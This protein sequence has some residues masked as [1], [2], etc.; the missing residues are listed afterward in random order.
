MHINEHQRRPVLLKV[1]LRHSPQRV[2]PQT[3]PVL[4]RSC[5]VKRLHKG[6]RISSEL[7]ALAIA[8]S[9]STK[10]CIHGKLLVCVVKQAS[11][12]VQAYSQGKKETLMHA[13]CLH[14]ISTMS[15][16]EQAI[17]NLASSQS[18]TI[19]NYCSCEPN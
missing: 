7:P 19:P 18:T 5:L 13:V 12:C 8:A 2:A 17:G 4:V 16:Q 15:N 9:L 10:P 14:S 3:R 1:C 11:D 6:S